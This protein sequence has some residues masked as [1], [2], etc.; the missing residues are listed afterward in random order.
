MANDLI[1][2]CADIQ[3]QLNTQ[4]VHSR[5]AIPQS[6]NQQKFILNS[7]EVLK[8]INDV[9]KIRPADVIKVL[10]RGAFL[11][12][13][14]FAGEC[15]AIKYGNSLQF[16]TDYKGEIKVIKQYSIKPIFDIYAEV[17]R[18]GDEYQKIVSADGK[19]TIEF[20]PKP[21]NDAPI[22]GAF[23]MVLY[24]DGSY[25]T[26]DIS[27]ADIEAIR[28]GFSKAPNSPA[29]RL[30]YPEMCK[31]TILRILCKHIN[32]NFTTEQ[33][34]AFEAGGDC[35]FNK[36]ESSEPVINPFADVIQAEVVEPP[37]EVIEENNDIHFCSKCGVEISEKVFAYS[38]DK[39]KE[40]LCYKCQKEITNG[41][42]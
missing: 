29:W 13:D 7:I 28:T 25:H 6:L 30:R 35:S 32:I 16:Q 41:E 33:Q 31:K 1:Q 19:K 21:F 12:L 20:K 27:K 10:M 4:L 26:E 15:Y 39:Y 18:E 42:Q 14:F 5:D 22:I 8:G 34:K 11:G 9:T 38:M 40:A 17:V 36:E 23:A 37:L 3:T 24:M 2:Y